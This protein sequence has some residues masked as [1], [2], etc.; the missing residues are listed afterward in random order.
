MKQKRVLSCALV[1]AV[2]FSTV[3][4]ASCDKQM[5]K[6][7]AHSLEFFD[8]ATTITGFEYTKE[9]FDAVSERILSELEEHHKL[10]TIYDGYDTIENL[11]DINALEDGAH[12]EVVV[13]KKII[14]MLLYSKEMYKLTNGKVNIAMGGLLSIWHDY[15]TEGLNEPWNAKLPP[16]EKL[17]QASGS[18]NIDNLIIDAEKNTVFIS[19]PKMKLDVGAVAKGYAVEMIA[20]GLERDGITGY[21]INV[22]GNV[23]TVGTKG[24]GEKWVVGIE[25]PDSHSDEQYIAYLQLSG[26]ALVTSGTYQRYYTVGDKNYHHIIDPDTLYPAEGYSSISVVCKSSA[27][28]DA[29]ST[30]LFCM[31][32][33]DGLNLVESLDG[34]EVLW[35]FEDGTQKQSSG[36]SKYIKE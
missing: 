16:K 23:R 4:F 6:Y 21:V 20:Q 11:A 31:D 19:D 10:F 27:D 3:F 25:N 9:E 8:T 18:I 2:I 34:I 32:F 33:E 24:D 26:E 7:S 12:R 28:G 17:E 5:I 35:V 22:G 29:L 36:F 14:D 15:R 13:D 30:A 1:V